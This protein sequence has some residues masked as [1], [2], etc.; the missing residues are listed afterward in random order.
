MGL[1]AHIRNAGYAGFGFRDLAA[2]DKLQPGPTRGCPAPPYR[3]GLFLITDFF[4]N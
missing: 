1:A 2:E 4:S 3:R